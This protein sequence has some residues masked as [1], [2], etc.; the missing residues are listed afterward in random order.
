[1]A[2]IQITRKEKAELEK[3]FPENKKKQLPEAF[4]KIYDFLM[5]DRAHDSEI[6][7]D[8]E[9]EVLSPNEAASL[10]HISRPIV[11]NLIRQGKL[12]SY[13]VNTHYR[14]KKLDILEYKKTL[15]GQR[16]E[17]FSKLN[18]SLN[19]LVNEEGWDD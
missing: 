3:V 4:Q 19:K 6:I 2:Q 10:L 8:D 12:A 5:K 15:E 18:Q 11:M 14:L 7:I 13:M 16:K 17:S 1:M 9:E